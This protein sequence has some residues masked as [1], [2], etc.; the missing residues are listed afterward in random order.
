MEEITRL[1]NSTAEGDACAK[2]ELLDAVYGELHRI[3]SAYMRREHRRD[4]TLQPTA[5]VNE[6]YLHLVGEQPISW[7]SRGHFFSAAA[8]TM[9]RILIDHARSQRAAKRPGSKERVQLE[10]NLIAVEEQAEEL[11]ALDAALNRL[12]ALNPRQA[13]VVELRFFGGL[14]VEETAHAAGTSEKK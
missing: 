11:L 5:L 2:A 7:D 4:H 3:A 9:R 14:T 1:L 12:A 13:Q 8:T 10:E 6:A